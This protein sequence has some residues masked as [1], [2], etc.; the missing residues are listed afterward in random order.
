MFADHGIGC[1]RQAEFLQS[2]STCFPWQIADAGLGKKT[3]DNDLFK[4]RSI[5]GCRN[6]S[7]E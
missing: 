6:G 2:Y 7:G 3:L 5:K 4:S 1:E